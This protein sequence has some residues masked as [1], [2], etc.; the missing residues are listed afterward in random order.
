MK[1]FVRTQLLN[2]GLWL[3]T[4]SADDEILSFISELQ[5]LFPQTPLKRFGPAGDGGYL[6]PDDIEHI[7]GCVSPGV[8]FECGFDKN[9]ADLGIDVYLADASVSAPPVSHKRFHFHK[10]F[11]DTF[12]SSETITIDDFCKDISPGEDLI[13]EMDIEGAEYRVLN[14]ASQQLLSKFRIMVI[15]FHDLPCIFTHFGL[16]EISFVFRRLL[17]THNIVHIHP[18][19]YAPPVSR[20]SIAIFPAMEFTFYRKDRSVFDQR[21]VAYPHPLD[22][23]NVTQ[24][25][26]APLPECWYYHGSSREAIARSPSSIA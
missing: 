10:L 17:K 24:M 16:R 5:P 8:S 25:P 15:E 13:L 7:G 18:N 14:S 9:L 26:D 12:N 11:F 2:C 6:M 19:N 4:T 20:G 23:K 22:F 3:Q 1:E 21:S